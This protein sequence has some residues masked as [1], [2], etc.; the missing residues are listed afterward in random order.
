M[1]EVKF[2]ETTVRLYDSIQDAPI[3]RF[4]AYQK[5]SLLDAGV[6]ST[7]N[8]VNTHFQ[9]LFQQLSAGDSEAAAKE[10]KNLFY[11]FNYILEGVNI[12]HYRFAVLV[13][14]I[15]GVRLPDLYPE[16][17]KQVLFDLSKKGLTNKAISDYLENVKKNF[18]QN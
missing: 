1:Y 3:E 2:N 9:K 16:T 18:G 5:Y 14:S 4:N 17:L 15:N 10:A 6:G 11:N 8:D 12:S 7:I 13:H